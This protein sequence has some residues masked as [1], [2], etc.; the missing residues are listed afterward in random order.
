MS[1]NIVEKINS[2]LPQTQCGQCNYS[3]CKP[4]AIAITKGRADINQCPPGGE[5]GIQN[6]AKLLGV[7]FKPLNEKHGITKPKAVAFIDEH[8]CIGCTLCILACPVDA[9]IGTT[10]KMHTIIEDECTGCELCLS[11]CPVDCIEILP[12]KEDNNGTSI[13][14]KSNLARSRY[15]FRLDRIKREKKESNATRKLLTSTSK[16][17]KLINEKRK[18]ISEAL[19]RIRKNE[20]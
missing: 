1:E 3:G 14:N 19:A 6:I 20:P 13:Q 5:E 8:A 16:K 15:E 7:D 9:I 17:S 18:S 10:K 12:V 11:P 2:I 4:Y